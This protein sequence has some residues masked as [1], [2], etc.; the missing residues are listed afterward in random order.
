[1]PPTECPKCNRFTV[2]A[3][4]C[5]ECDVTVAATVPE[6]TVSI[7]DVKPLPGEVCPCCGYKVPEKSTGRVKAWRA[8]KK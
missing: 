7:P 4:R 3:G 2:V 8:K 6:E 5:Q 1:M